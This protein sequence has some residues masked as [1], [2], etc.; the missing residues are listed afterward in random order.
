MHLLGIID[1]NVL[2]YGDVKKIRAIAFSGCEF[3]IGNME[4]YG[5]SNRVCFTFSIV[6][7]LC[8]DKLVTN[9]RRLTNDLTAIR[10][11]HNGRDIDLSALK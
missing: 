2:P 1:V 5:H 11:L 6:D 10:I 4:T 8:V 3:G 9:M 7:V